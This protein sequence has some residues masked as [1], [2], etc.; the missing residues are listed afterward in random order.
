VRSSLEPT[1]MSL[2]TRVTVTCP[3]GDSF[4]AL[5]TMSA[6]GPETLQR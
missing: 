5:V 4:T 1:A 2:I 6:A 3:A